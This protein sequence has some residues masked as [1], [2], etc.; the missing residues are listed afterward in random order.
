VEAMRRDWLLELEVVCQ[1]VYLIDTKPIPVVGYKRS[2]KRSA[3]AGSATFGY[4]ASRNL[5]YFGYKLVMITTLDGL[6]IV[7]DLVPANTDER[8]AAE[9]VLDYVSYVEILGDKG[10]LGAEWQA[11]MLQQTH[12][13]ITTPH[14]INQLVQHPDGFEKLLNSMRERIEG[15][16]HE[17]QNTGRNIERLLAKTLVGLTTRV[18]VKVTA[19]LLRYLLRHHLGIDVQTFRCSSDA[20]F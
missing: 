19:H 2:K 7:Y 18:I 5:H 10:F 12:N 6:P 11:Q 4:C 3:F 17:L 20:V 13:T 15:V 16:F 1:G 14:R 9:A 8:T